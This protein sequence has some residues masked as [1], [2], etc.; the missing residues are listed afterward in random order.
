MKRTMIFMMSAV[1]GVMAAVGESPIV[2]LP[3]CT[4]TGRVTDYDN[5]ALENWIDNAEVRISKKGVLLAKGKIARYDADT[6]CNYSV[7]V[8]MS[9]TPECAAAAAPGDELAFVV[10]ARNHDGTVYAS[11]SNVIVAG[12]SAATVRLD[13]QLIDCTNPW[14]IDDYYISEVEAFGR[15]RLGPDGKPYI[16]AGQT[17]DPNADYDG[18]G[19]SNIDEYRAGTSPFD[20]EEAGLTITSFQA[21]EADDGT[22]MFEIAFRPAFGFAYSIESADRPAENIKDF[23]VHAHRESPEAAAP[24]RRYFNESEGGVERKFYLPKKTGASIELFRVHAQ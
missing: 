7:V 21:I 4:Y 8:P 15:S 14:G 20:A 22:E 24:E 23:S 5:T 1:A 18:D 17:Y 9:T 13:L 6:S 3:P 10:D 2:A 11:V 12:N 19:V 16:A